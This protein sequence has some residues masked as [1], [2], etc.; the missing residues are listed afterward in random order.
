M[1]TGELARPPWRAAKPPAAEQA[2]TTAH[3]P[4]NVITTEADYHPAGATMLRARCP[5]P[6]ATCWRGSIQVVPIY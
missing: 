6:P 2:A 3:E 4:S 5:A 1:T